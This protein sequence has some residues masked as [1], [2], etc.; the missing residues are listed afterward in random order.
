[1]KTSYEAER[2]ILVVREAPGQA[3]LAAAVVEVGD[4]AGGVIAE[5]GER[6]R[7]AWGAVIQRRLPVDPQLMGPPPGEQAGVRRQGPGRGREGQVEPHPAAGQS[8][9]IGRRPAAVA[10]QAQIPGPDRVPDDQQHIPGRSGGGGRAATARC[11]DQARRPNVPSITASRTRRAAG[12]S[13]APTGGSRRRRG[14][15]SRA[16]WTASPP[17]SS[18][19]AQSSRGSRATSRGTRRRRAAPRLIPGGRPGARARRPRRASTRQQHQDRDPRG[20]DPGEI[21]AEAEEV[22]VDQA[23]RR[24]RAP[25]RESLRP[26]QSGRHQKDRRRPDSHGLRALCVI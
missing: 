15:T 1:M 13:G 14:P 12:S 16:D 22:A 5:G 24:S 20:N 9:E 25:G 21:L 18:S 19:D 8:L 3:G 23:I 6:T 26:G 7:R 10:V 11:S 2:V 17:E 4:E